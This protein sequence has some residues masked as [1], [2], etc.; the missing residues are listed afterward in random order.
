MRREHASN[1]VHVALRPSILLVAIAGLLTAGCEGSPVDRM[2]SSSGPSCSEREAEARAIMARP[3][4]AENRC[5]VDGDCR[6]VAG[7]PACWRS[8]GEVRSNADAEV[9]AALRKEAD[10]G[11]CKDFGKR[12]PM[13]GPSCAPP[14][15]PVCK[16]GTCVAGPPAQP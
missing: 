6:F 14:P 2:L 11:P 13:A 1:P 3:G 15:T 7:S 5:E 8:C 16:D 9:Y 4:K 10:E 12:C